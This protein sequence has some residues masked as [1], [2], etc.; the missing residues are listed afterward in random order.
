MILDGGFADWND[1]NFA[2]LQ[3]SRHCLTP[4]ACALLERYQSVR[5]ASLWRRVAAFARSP[6]RRQTLL[7]NI[8]LLIGVVLKK[9]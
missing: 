3:R 9:V 8:A 1:V 6:L 5:T 2:A 7:G 4:E